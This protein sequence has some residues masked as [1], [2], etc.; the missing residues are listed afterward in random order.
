MLHNG[1]HAQVHQAVGMPDIIVKTRKY[2]YI[3]EVKLDST[4]D[5][6]LRQLEEK[7]YAIPYLMDGQEIIKLGVSFSSKMKT[8]NE[9]KRG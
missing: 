2:I 6:A 9:W 8:I 5:E 4:P 3:I 1:A 7:Q